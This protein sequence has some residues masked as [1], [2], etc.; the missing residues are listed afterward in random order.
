MDAFPSTLRDLGRA[1][2]AEVGMCRA[3]PAW[4]IR[5][6]LPQILAKYYKE[7]EKRY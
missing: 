7:V 5:D 3:L 1:G 4:R 2:A 6:G